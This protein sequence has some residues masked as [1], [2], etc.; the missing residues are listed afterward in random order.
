[1]QCD[2]RQE[3]SKLQK[4][5]SRKWVLRRLRSVEVTSVRSRGVTLRESG[6]EVMCEE[7]SSKVVMYRK[8]PRSVKNNACKGVQTTVGAVCT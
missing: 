8:K 4:E 1:M 3:G 2:G 7:Q 6:I 5:G